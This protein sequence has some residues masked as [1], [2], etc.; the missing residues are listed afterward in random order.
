VI[1]T[2]AGRPG[3]RDSARIDPDVGRFAVDRVGLH[4]FAFKTPTLRNVA[5]TAPYMHNG[6]FRTLEEVLDFYDGGW[7]CWPGHRGASADV[8][9]RLAP[10][11]TR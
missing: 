10:P 4:R 6:V 11:L 5:L 9:P 1:G 8:A 7:W 3:T 2:P